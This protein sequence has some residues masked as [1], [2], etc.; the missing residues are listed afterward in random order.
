MKHSPKIRHRLT[1]MRRPMS[2]RFWQTTVRKLT[3]IQ[4]SLE[5]L[6]QIKNKTRRSHRRR[7]R[8][9][10]S[11]SDTLKTRCLKWTYRMWA[12]S[13]CE[14]TLMVTMKRWVH[15]LQ[16]LVL[17]CLCPLLSFLTTVSFNRWCWLQPCRVLFWPLRRPDRLLTPRV[18][19]QDSSR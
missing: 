11:G 16:M 4:R 10:R 14:L 9:G 2:K 12:G 7:R 5:K 17:S 3:T 19:K 6:H 13:P 15:D 8:S 1:F 18:Q